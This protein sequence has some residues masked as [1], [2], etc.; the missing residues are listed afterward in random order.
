MERRPLLRFVVTVFALLPACFLLWFALS[1]F[2]TAPAVMVAKPILLGW[3]PDLIDTVQLH[4]AQMM[5]LSGFGESG[6]EIVAADVAG[7]QLG[8]PVNTRVMSYSMP[9]FAALHFATPQRARLE[10]FAWCLVALWTLLAIGLIA[11]TMKNLMLGLGSTFVDA[12]RVPPADAIALA[13]QFSTIMVPPLAPVIL[14]AVSASDSA[15][16]RSLLPA[17]LRPAPRRG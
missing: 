13:Y 10:R 7:N 15:T 5:V 17:S 3:L 8:Y 4:G 11:T 9:F 6:G 1:S 16:F 14:W 12:P 2:L